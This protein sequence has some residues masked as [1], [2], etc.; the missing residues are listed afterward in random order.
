MAKVRLLNSTKTICPF[1]GLEIGASYLKKHQQTKR[2]R[3][4]ALSAEIEE[5]NLTP[6]EG[7]DG[8]RIP[9]ANLLMGY[10][11]LRKLV[12]IY[13]VY[14]DGVLRNSGMTKYIDTFIVLVAMRAYSIYE[15]KES[16]SGYSVAKY[17]NGCALHKMDMDEEFRMLCESVYR[18]GGDES[19]QELIKNTC[20]E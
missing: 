11:N 5:R 16:D 14:T 2:C 7:R 1:C 8:I 10:P 12:K 20:A 15:F 17:I 4:Y 6:I 19:L 13:P 3:I 18:M 9:C